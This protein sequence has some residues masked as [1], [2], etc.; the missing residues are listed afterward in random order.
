MN[1]TKPRWKVY[2]LYILLTEAVGALAAALTQEA[3]LL[4]GEIITKPPLSPPAWVF[5]VAWTL[6]YALMG[7][8]AAR[9]A[10]TPPTAARR[11]AL[12]LFYAQ[13]VVNFLW[14]IWFFSFGAYGFAFL[15]LVLLWALVVRMT[16]AFRE[17]DRTAARTQIPY[18]LWLLFAGYLNFGVWRLN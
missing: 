18:L 15:W 16:L 2:L 5:P 3:A 9:V 12:R 4:Y 14:S 11:L 6:L 17:L 10:L 7:F 13:L 8:G 1:M